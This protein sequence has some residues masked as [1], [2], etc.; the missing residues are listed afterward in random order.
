MARPKVMVPPE[1][2]TPGMSASIW[3]MPY[4]TASFVVISSIVFTC[5]ALSSTIHRM[6]PNTSSM[7]AVIHR[8]R[9]V[10]S[11]ASWNSRPAKT[12]GSVAMMMYQPRRASLLPSPRRCF[13][14]LP[15]LPVRQMHQFLRMF[16]MSWRK[17]SST[18]SS[19][20]I[21]M[22]AVNAAPGSLPNMRSPTMRTCA[23]DET[24]R[25]S[26]NACT[27]PRNIAWKKFMNPLNCV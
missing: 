17:Y 19:V 7:A 4:H 9:S 22:I 18:A 10:F 27:N 20:P 14:S 5:G 13:Q 12:I 1:R 25:Y 2:D 15:F 26:V 21:W 3:P 11:M 6:M 16:Q 8:L 24:G 23:L